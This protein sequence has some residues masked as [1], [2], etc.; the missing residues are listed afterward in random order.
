[1]CSTPENDRD[2]FY[3]ILATLREKIGNLC[4]KDCD[5]RMDW[6][7]QGLYFFFEPGEYRRDEGIPRV[8]RVGTHAVSARSKTTLWNR[9]STHRGTVKTGG[10]NHRGSIFRLHVGGA[11][12]HRGGSIQLSPN[13]WGQGS[14]APKEIREVEHPVEQ[15]VSGYI[16]RMPFLFVRAEDAAGTSSVRAIIERNSI[17]LLSCSSATGESADRA[18]STWLGHYCPHDVVRESSL[19]NVRE[20]DGEY[21]PSFLDVLERC[22]AQ[23]ECP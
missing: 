2:R 1:M 14:S 22:A 15:A 23:T 17:K 4:L 10:G 9:L 5:G 21:D 12:L 16:R 7:R 20:T 11:L 8:V 3:E 13:T 18:S 19:W 6:P